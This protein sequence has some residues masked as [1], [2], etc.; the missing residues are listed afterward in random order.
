VLVRPYTR[1]VSAW[2]ADA[3]SAF[4][5]IVNLL[6]AEGA[7]V[8]DRDV[9]G[10]CAVHAAAYSD[11]E[12]VLEAIIA[13]FPGGSHAAF[14][15]VDSSGRTAAHIAASRSAQLL[16]AILDTSIDPGVVDANGNS[17]MHYAA[18][19][20]SEDCVSLLIPHNLVNVANTS[21]MT[22]LF[23]AAANGW[24]SLVHMLLEEGS[25]VNHLSL[26]GDLALHY[27]CARGSVQ[28]VRELL[29]KGAALTIAGSRGRLPF[30]VAAAGGH[31][32]VCDALLEARPFHEY[33]VE[34]GEVVDTGSTVQYFDLMATLDA[35]K[36]SVLHAACM[37]PATTVS[38]GVVGGSC[39]SVTECF[40]GVGLSADAQDKFGRTPLHYAAM[41]VDTAA[42]ES[43]L[44]E[45]SE[46]KLQTVMIQDEH[47]C[48][49]LHYAAQADDE[50]QCCTVLTNYGG[51]ELVVLVD[52]L[53][54]TACHE[55]AYYGKWQALSRMLENYQNIANVC[56]SNG[57]SPL[58][59]AAIRGLSDVARVLLRA[60]ADVNQADNS[61]R[62]PLMIAAH[63]GWPELCRLLLQHRSCEADCEDA[64]G[65]TAA[66]YAAAGG[67]YDCIVELGRRGDLHVPDS[68]GVTPLMLAV[69]NGHADT[70]AELFDGDIDSLTHSGVNALH[71]A[72]MVDRLDIM[73]KLLDNGASIDFEYVTI[74][75]MSE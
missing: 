13:A 61:G 55:A 58:Y 47:G 49:A 28:C 16:K 2:N 19:A 38:E 23:C 7:S 33:V 45:V 21:G 44:E 74:V 64:H 8:T 59:V 65:R 68:Q 10:L 18:A 34:D 46:D 15:A 29:D 60:N 4:A 50:G 20:G 40:T 53:G 27:A 51:R 41:R 43:L 71:I 67:H 25:R 37:A 9:L 17:L 56:D 57:A 52:K 30:H 22:P 6:R 35:D 63:Y 66:H 62:T 31:K 11:D 3:H 1:L 39:V 5:Q 70:V 24:H 73:R 26:Q 42:V 72:A 14:T 32:E 54:R 75:N 48:S 36:R 12:N 69:K